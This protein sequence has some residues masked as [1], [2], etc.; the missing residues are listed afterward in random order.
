MKHAA[1]KMAYKK[2]TFLFVIVKSSTLVMYRSHF[3]QCKKI[4][5]LYRTLV[6]R[7]PKSAVLGVV[8]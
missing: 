1:E 7:I 8:K 2:R 5:F 6:F 4:I 3:F